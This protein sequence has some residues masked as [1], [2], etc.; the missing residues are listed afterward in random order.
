MKLTFRKSSIA[1]LGA[2]ALSGLTFAQP[3]P[4]DKPAEIKLGIT[5]FLSG[6]ASVFGVPAKAAADLIIDELNAKG[7]KIGD[8]VVRQELT[9]GGGHASG[10]M[11]WMHFGLGLATEVQVRVQWPQS[12]WSEWMPAK[13][14][15]FYNVTLQ[16]ITKWTAP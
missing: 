12:T 11:G 6:P 2:L 14:D 8:K 7:I 13:A 4:A 9:V 3:K 16:G 1:L 5:T 15:G 10:H